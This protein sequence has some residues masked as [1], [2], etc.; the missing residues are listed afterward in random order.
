MTRRLEKAL[1]IYTLSKAAL[2][3]EALGRASVT[4]DPIRASVTLDPI[5]ATNV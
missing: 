5:P 4:L 3:A 1:L 2:T